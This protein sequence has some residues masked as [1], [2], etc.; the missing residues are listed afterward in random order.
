MQIPFNNCSVQLDLSPQVLD[1]LFVSNFLLFVYN[2]DKHLCKTF[3][4]GQTIFMSEIKISFYFLYP[5]HLKRKKENNFCY[6]LK[7]FQ[8]MCFGFFVTFLHC[9]R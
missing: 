5:L 4:L 9:Q 6:T 8:N 2:T 3:F 1:I 7:I